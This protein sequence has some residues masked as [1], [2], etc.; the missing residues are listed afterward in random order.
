MRI[1][2]E[3]KQHMVLKEEKNERKHVKLNRTEVANTQ[4]RL[5][6]VQQT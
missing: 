5:K 1:L 4:P 6:K 3:V 2:K